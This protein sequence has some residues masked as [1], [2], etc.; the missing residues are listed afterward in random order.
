MDFPFLRQ[1]LTEL[2]KQ[3][4]SYQLFI[5]YS[6]GR[7]R[8]KKS[9]DEGSQR[10][11]TTVDSQETVN[12][13]EESEPEPEPSKKMPL[14]KE[15]LRRKSNYLK[16]SKKASRRQPGNQGLKEGTDSKTGVLGESTVISATS[17]EGTGNKL[18]VFDEENDATEEKVILEFG[19]EQNSEYSDDDNGDF[20][21][22]DKDSDAAD[23]EGDD[24][25]SDT[26]DADDEDV[27]TE[28]DEDDIYKYKICV[29]KDEDEEMINVE[30]VDSDKGDEEITNVAKADAKKSLEAKDDAKKTELPPL[31]SRLYVS[32][33]FVTTLPPPS[34]STTPTLPQQTTTPIPTQPIITDTLTI[35][36]VVPESNAL[37]VVELRVGKLEKDVSELKIVDHS[38]E[39]L[40]IL[41]SQVPFIV[42]NYLG[43][44]VG[45]V[46]QKELKKHTTDLIKKYSLLRYEKRSIPIYAC[47]QV[48]NTNPV[49]HRLYHALM[50]ALIEDE[51]AIDKGVADTVKDHKRKHDDNEDNDDEDP[52]FGQNQGKKT[53]RRRT[54]ESEYSKNPSYTKETSKGKAPTKGS[55]TGKSASTKEQ[56]EEPITKV[57]MD[58]AGDDVTRAD[59]QPHDTS[60]PK[61]RK[62]LN[63]DWFKQPL[64]VFKIGMNMD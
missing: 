36:T 43:S 53:K 24:N 38:T 10:K 56:V 59:N 32:S 28:S 22:D 54:K 1:I 50:K 2:I 25:I 47:K 11:K 21:K 41:K 14:V 12:V 29:Y 35:T 60:K 63:L 5:K 16:E 61:T 8:S 37:I 26:Q 17:N 39:A 51:K 7:I 40:A 58:D 49:N 18:G 55:K 45:D 57:V 31:S 62:T 20:K 3:Y 52:P 42:D 4:E 9:R 44:K 15:E 33:G 13:S 30:V 46:F 6:T 27:K 48:F 34:V 19:D 23:D 64:W